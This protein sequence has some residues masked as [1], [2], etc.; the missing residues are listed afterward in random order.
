MGCPH[1]LQDSKVGQF[2]M[3]DETFLNAI[4]FG[5]FID[6]YRYNISGGEPTSH[7]RFKELI[8]ILISHLESERL[9]LNGI[10]G[11]II[12]RRFPSFTI[13][14]NGEFI[15]DE[16]LF[17]FLVKVL[18]NECMEYL[19]VCS[20]KGLYKNFELI[21]RNQSKIM[22]MHS[23]K[24]CVHTSG[25]TSMKDLGRAANVDKYRKSAES[26]KYYMSCLNC[27]LASKQLIDP[28]QFSSTMFASD[29]TCK[30]FI[31]WKGDVHLSES[32]TCPS[33]GNVNTDD[34][35]DIWNGIRNF[36]PCGR[37]SGYRK[38]INSDVPKIVA[39]KRIL[40]L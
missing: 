16:E 31:D 27:S 13:E 28:K 21:K 10:L 4:K 15:K 37:C 34:F 5:K 30:P 32:I 38:F 29:Q 2:H 3:T 14:S 11:H 18:K 25:I 40:G 17:K 9:E 12:P 26:D 22:S 7:P 23:V 24:V 19:Q 36:K 39:A 1:C 33:V 6:N 8:E 35:L 20:I